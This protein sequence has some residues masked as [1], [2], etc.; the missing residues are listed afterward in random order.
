MLFLTVLPLHPP[1]FLVPSMIQ[2]I[3]F[4]SEIGL[5]D[6]VEDFA[7]DRVVERDAVVVVGP[8]DVLLDEEV[9]QRAVEEAD[10]L[11]VVPKG[12][13]GI[14][15]ADQDIAADGDVANRAGALVEEKTLHQVVVVV[16]A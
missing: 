15:K 7:V 10:A 12:L 2:G 13:V 9:H 16:I 3:I 1:T 6:V 11:R 5:H 8:D 4:C 14:F